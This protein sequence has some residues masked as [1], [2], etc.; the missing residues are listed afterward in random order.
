MDPETKQRFDT[1]E[2]AMVRLAEGQVGLSEGLQQTNAAV[3]ELAVEMRALAE[4]Q[5]RTEER[6]GWFAE[7]MLRGFDRVSGRVTTL[8]DRVEKL[9]GR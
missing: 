1:L 8:E 6:M 7:Q 4:A 5:K 9:D 2:N 3:R